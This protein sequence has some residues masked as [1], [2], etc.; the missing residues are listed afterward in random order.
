MCT[1]THVSHA[2]TIPVVDLHDFT[3]GDAAR[4]RRFVATLGDGLLEYGFIAVD[5]HGVRPAT[6]AR[7]YRAIDEVFA[8]PAAAKAGY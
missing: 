1:L 4:Q 5:N 8:L 7:A 3:R 6:I 2:Q